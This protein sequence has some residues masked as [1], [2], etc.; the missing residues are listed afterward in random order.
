MTAQA[1]RRPNSSPIT[2]KMKSVCAAGRKNIFCSLCP[3]PTPAT[4]PDPN[5]ISDWR[6]WKP[7][8][9]GSFV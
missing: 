5:E 1:P 7:I 2:E 4:P 3:S 9:C 6:S 8:P